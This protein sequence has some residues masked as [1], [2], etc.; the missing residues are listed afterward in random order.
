MVR[1][2]F[3]VTSIE[4][5]AAYNSSVPDTDHVKMSPVTDE[6]NKTWSKWTPGGSLEMQINNPAA[7][8]QFKVGATYFVDF[9]EAPQAEADEKAPA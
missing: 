9:T 4:K 3:R 1:A 2:K 8:D 5:R 7:L 6:A